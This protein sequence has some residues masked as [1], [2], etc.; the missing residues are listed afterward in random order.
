MDYT[1]L[2]K[3]YYRL[4]YT[5][6]NSYKKYLGS[7]EDGHDL[8]VEDSD[9][10]YKQP[11]FIALSDYDLNINAGSKEYETFLD[12]YDKTF[13]DLHL[14]FLGKDGFSAIYNSFLE[15][16]QIENDSFAVEFLNDYLDIALKMY[17][18]NGV[19]E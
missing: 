1:N 10:F 6:L 9:V 8:E 12:Y 11:N 2:I 16:K 13:P 7:I 5:K 19:I 14:V 18:E 15:S 3:T 4:V 17:A